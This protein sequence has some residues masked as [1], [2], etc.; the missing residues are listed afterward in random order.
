VQVAIAIE[1]RQRL[2]VA[3]RPESEPSIFPDSGVLDPSDVIPGFQLDVAELFS[4][5]IA[6]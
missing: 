5:L 4:A 2:L 6:D 1:P 3:F